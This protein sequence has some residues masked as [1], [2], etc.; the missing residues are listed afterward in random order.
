MNVTQRGIVTLLKST[1]TGEQLK[2]PDGFELEQAGDLI[3]GHHLH[4]LVYQGAV[5]CGISCREPQMQELFKVCVKNTYVSERQL[6]EVRRIYDAFEE[7]SIEYMPLKGCRMKY[8]YPSPELRIMG[9]ADILI[10]ME[11]Y[12]QIRLVLE[13]LGFEEKNESDHELI[14]RSKFLVLELHKRLIP[15]YNQD[16]YAYY[17]DGWNLAKVREGNACAMT[18]EDEWVYLFTHFAKHF[19]DGGIG[20]RHVVDLWVYRRTYPILD[21]A[22]VQ[23]VLLR[24]GLQEFYENICNLLDVWFD[25]KA[26]DEKTEFLGEVIFASGSWGSLESRTISRAL[27]YSI[28]SKVGMRG[29]MA[30]LWETAF[31]SAEVLRGKYI[32]LKRHPWMLPLVWAYRPVYKVIFERKSLDRKKTELNVISEK[33]M[34]GRQRLLNYIGLDYDF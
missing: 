2:L 21:E 24:L 26:E 6:Q 14:W 9:D 4:V 12:E 18:P 32:V 10:R 3:R 15:S 17:G 5:K 30:Y 7:N 25:G 20:C 33:D 13:S 1:V 16:F 11:Q 8:L 23:S 34:I 28:T 22:Y 29:K 31:P 19:R 27:R